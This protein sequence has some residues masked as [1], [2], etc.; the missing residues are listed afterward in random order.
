[1]GRLPSLIYVHDYVS[2]IIQKGYAQW[3]CFCNS[4]IDVHPHDIM[5]N[6]QTQFQ[7]PTDLFSLPSLLSKNNS[8]D[9][10]SNLVFSFGGGKGWYNLSY[11]VQLNNFMLKLFHI[12]HLISSP[13]NSHMWNFLFFIFPP[14]QHQLLLEFEK[15]HHIEYKC[16]F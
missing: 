8:N 2:L 6:T 15:S 13:F 14:K 10:I 9:K 5:A 3:A 12:C 11:G 1:M 16:R 7:Y 4:S